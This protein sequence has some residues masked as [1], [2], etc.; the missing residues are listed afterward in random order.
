MARIGHQRLGMYLT[1]WVPVDRRVLSI[2]GFVLENDITYF[3][4]GAVKGGGM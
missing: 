3:I 2:H 4:N 1:E